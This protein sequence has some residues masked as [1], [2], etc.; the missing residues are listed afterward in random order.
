MRTRLLPLTALAVL[1]VAGMTGG[2]ASAV[3]REGF[4][5]SQ[6]EPVEKEYPAM[7]AGAPADE[8]PL[9]I[10]R[11]SNCAA[12]A[13]V[14][15]DTMPMEIIPPAG[16]QDDRDIFFTIVELHWDNSAGNDLNLVLYDNGQTSGTQEQVGA[17]ES[18]R[19]P[20]VARI[21]NADL[22]EYHIVV[23]NGSGAN[24]GYTIKA[25][26]TTDPFENPNESL[27]PDPPKAEEPEPEEAE[28]EFTPPEDKS[29]EPDPGSSGPGPEPT[30]PPVEGGPVADDDFDFGFSD[31]DDRITVN[32]DDL[33]TNTA[34]PVTPK[35]EKVSPAVLL[36]SLI[37][38]PALI[39]GSG[40]AFAWKR[41]R[42]LLL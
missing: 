32:L 35:A 9:L 12:A 20:E 5:V 28:E 8:A 25:R 34:A 41:R 15:C 26:V 1:L 31:L 4:T 2:P 18:T 24:T 16:L 36:A 33:P 27:T 39:V 6:A 42:E 19:M 22:G 29:A 11:P 17:S 14:D 3:Q 7:G 10:F 40:V 37:G 21:P 30:L 13:R 23:K 38:A